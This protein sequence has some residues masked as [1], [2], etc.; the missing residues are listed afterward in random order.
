MVEVIVTAT[1]R[2]AVDKI[3]HAEIKERVKKQIQKI[4]ELP[5]AGKPLRYDFKGARSLRVPPF[6][7][8]YAFH[9]GRL[10]LLNFEHR[11]TAYD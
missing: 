1:F 5:D 8:I 9:E 10:Y 11:K 4:V 6:R 3:K 7:I 2:R